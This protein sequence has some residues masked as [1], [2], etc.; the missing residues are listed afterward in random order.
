MDSALARRNI[1][2]DLYKIFLAFLVICIHFAGEAYGHFPLYRLAVP[3][4]FMISGYFMYH[5]D[6]EQRLRKA[7]AFIYRNLRYMLI[8]FGLYILYDFVMCYIKGNGVGY[9]FTT[10][11]YDDLFL[12]FFIL[13]TPIT[14]SGYQLW[15]LIALLVVSLIHFFLTK[16]KKLR[17]YWWIIPAGIAIYLFFQGYMKLFQYTDMPIRYTRNALFFGLPNFAIGYLTAKRT[18]GKETSLK[19]RLLFLALGLA[20]FFLQILESKLIVMEQYVSTVLANYFLLRF[21]LSLRG[22]RG[23]LYYRI[24]GKNLSFYIYI[25]HVAVGITFGDL[26]TFPTPMA[27]C[28]VVFLLSIGLYECAFWAWKLLKKPAR[29]LWGKMNGV[30]DRLDEEESPVH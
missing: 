5:S 3:G 15:F 26:F 24:F 11:F 20:F 23:D 10:L 28:A 8:G 27:K 7:K 25:L 4:F 9:F 17:H 2:I 29:V 12:D 22:V 18:K 13:N 30:V 1:W 21:F 16:Y 14:Y 6:E 19:K